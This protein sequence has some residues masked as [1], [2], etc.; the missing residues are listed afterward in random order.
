MKYHHFR[1]AVRSKILLVKR[2]DTTDRLA[3]IFTKPLA[4]IPLEHLRKKI[5]GWTAMLSH[6]NMDILIYEHIRNIFI[7]H[8]YI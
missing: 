7:G 5:M 6:G 8:K 4:R 2:V 3:D 1:E